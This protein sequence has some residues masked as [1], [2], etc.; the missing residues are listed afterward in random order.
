MATWVAYPGPPARSI[1]SAESQLWSNDQDATGMRR[2]CRTAEPWLDSSVTAAG[3]GRH[4]EQ[5]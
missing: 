3:G 5:K 1:I 2:L 4:F